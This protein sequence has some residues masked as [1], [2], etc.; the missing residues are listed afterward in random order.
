MENLLEIKDLKIEFE[1]QK[2]IVS[3]VDGIDLTV[4]KGETLCIVGESGCGKSVTSLSVMR[5]LDTPP[6]HYS[7]GQ[8][9]FEGEDLLQKTEKQM[10][11]IRGNKIAMIFQEPMTALNPVYT[12]GRQLTETI[13]RHNKDMSKQDIRKRA[14]E[15]LGTVGIRD[16]ER[17]LNEYPHQL[18]GGMRQRVMIAIALS[19]GP[20]LLIADEPTTALDVTIQAQ[21]LNLLKKLKQELNMTIILITHD[22]G[23]VAQ[24]ADRVT[25]MYGGTVVEE[26]DVHDFFANPRHPYTKALLA[27]IPR[28]DMPKDTLY[29][30][31]GSVPNLL[32]RPEGCIFRNRC[33]RAADCCAEKKPVL[34][35]NGGHGAACHFPYDKENEE[36]R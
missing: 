8:I 33:P 16:P 15:L 10:C 36:V 13:R 26:S 35:W 31:T 23:V 20:E 12:I 3:A 14:V 21:I 24:M 9:L 11:D 17:R 6:A 27:C 25:V 30:I 34:E 32:E 7:G 28:L 5:L 18:S 29:T 1:T 19:C 4:K 2:G 22:L